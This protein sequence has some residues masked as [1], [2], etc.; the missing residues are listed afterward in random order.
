MARP[1]KAPAS[2]VAPAPEGPPATGP[3]HVLI[4]GAGGREHAIGWKLKQAKRCG[5]IW[6]SPGN[7]GTREVGTNV[8]LPFDPVNTKNADAIARFCRENKVG[9]V[10]IGPEDPL[11]AGLADRLAAP[12]RAVFGP[13]AEAAKLEGDKAWAKDLMR[14]R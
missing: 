9:L 8:D 1:S 2:R 12:G 3:V 13:V 10:V 6:F 7:G 14:G 5:K 4:L 11:C